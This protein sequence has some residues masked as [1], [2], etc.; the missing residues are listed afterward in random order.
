MDN[1]NRVLKPNDVAAMLR[2]ETATIRR[3]ANDG[4]LKAHVTPGGHRR[5]D[6]GEIRRFAAEHGIALQ[7]SFEN[8][9]KILVVDDDKR[10]ARTIARMLSASKQDV[11]VQCAF[12]GF[13]AGQ[14]VATYGPD[15]IVLDLFMPGLDG[16]SLCRVLKNDPET[17]GIRIIAITGDPDASSAKRVVKLGAEVCLPKPI[18]KDVLFKA[19]GLD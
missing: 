1:D 3:W 7:T 15:V 12:D 2:V 4:L 5:F 19:I 10:V 9:T 11:Q 14:T 16:F 8:V 17:A 13:S 6:F 18:K